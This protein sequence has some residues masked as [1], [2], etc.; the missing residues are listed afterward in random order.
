MIYENVELHN[1]AEV[2]PLDDGSGVALQRVPESVR[3]VLNDCAKRQMQRPG[4]AEIRFFSEGDT[5]ELTLS[6]GLADGWKEVHVVPF[7]GAYQHSESFKV[8][9]EKQTIRL[10]MSDRLRQTDPKYLDDSTFSHNVWRFMCW[11]GQVQL[12]TIEG[13]GIRPPKPQE[14]PS[15]R[16]LTYGTSITH[17]HCSS[18]PHLNYAGQTARALGADLINLGSCGS[19]YCEAELSDYIA[20]RD[21]WDIA[22]LAL[23][24]NMRHFALDEFYTRVSYMVNTVSGANLDRPVACITL[25]PFFDDMPDDEGKPREGAVA[26]PETFRQ[27]LRDAVSACPNPNVH[28]LEGPELMTDTTG[29]TDDLIHPGDYGMM[30]MGLNLAAALKP[31]LKN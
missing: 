12:H 30:E 27:L 5:C 14:L 10:T 28:L 15:V 9:R 29:L 24:V 8:G 2:K 21:D 3:S 18:G 4:G 17:G 25:W 19:A 20:A 6:C 31:L 23:S 22:T 11:G 26:R 7:F 1:V 13:E 16:L